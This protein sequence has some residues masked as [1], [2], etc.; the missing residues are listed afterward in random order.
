[1]TI[2]GLKSKDWASKVYDAETASDMNIPLVAGQVIAGKY[3]S[4]LPTFTNGQYGLLR[5]TA[6]GK[7]MTDAVL[8]TGDIEIG[9]VE[10]K[11]G[12]SDVR[13]IINAANTARTTGDTTLVMQHID[14][15]ANVG[16]IQGQIAH[17]AADNGNPIKIG[18]FAVDPTALPSAVATADRVNVNASTHGEVL[19]YPSRLQS[20]EDQ[21]N[22]VMAVC[23]KSLATSTYAFAVDNSAALEAST[24]TKAAAGVLYQVDGRID[25]TAATGTYYIQFINAASLPADGAVTHLRT[26]KKL[27]HTTGTDTPFSFD[28]GPGGIYAP[29]GIVL[30]ASSTEFTKTITGA[31]TTSTV[32]YQ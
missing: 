30:C 23:Q 25:S 18:A 29:V 27:Q 10:L 28:F 13:A 20:G 3:T 6:D 7:L 1:M 2:E 14:A 4:G 9:A 17:D 11:N 24:V 31:I 19:V 32:L 16:G 12:S 26:P 21:V 5:L 15:A 22:N 8:E